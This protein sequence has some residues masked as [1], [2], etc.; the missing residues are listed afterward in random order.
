[1]IASLQKNYILVVLSVILASI[2]V[3][4]LNK[5]QPQKD[6]KRVYVKTIVTVAL[7]SAMLVD[8][9]TLYPQLEEVI[10]SPPPF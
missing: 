8:I 7:I 4:I 9:H 5:I 1:M 2:I 3:F 10:T 6:E